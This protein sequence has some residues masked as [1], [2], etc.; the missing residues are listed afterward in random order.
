MLVGQICDYFAD[1]L[2]R[3][4]IAQ[5]HAVV[6]VIH[7]NR[8]RW[9]AIVT[10]AHFDFLPCSHSFKTLGPLCHLNVLP[11]SCAKILPCRWRAAAIF[12][13]SV[14]IATTAP[15]INFRR[16]LFTLSPV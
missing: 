2:P 3:K 6:P 15:S 5:G 4:V 8:K 14:E 9:S 1:G 16:G 10:L 12:G 7:W 13:V 11:L